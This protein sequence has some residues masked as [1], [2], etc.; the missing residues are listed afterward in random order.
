MSAKG[1]R[2]RTDVTT[3]IHLAWKRRLVP[4]AWLDFDHVGFASVVTFLVARSGAD[5]AVPTRRDAVRAELDA[6]RRPLDRELLVDA[7]WRASSESN[8][9]LLAV[10]DALAGESPAATGSGVEAS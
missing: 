9:A 3:L 10:I 2:I 4:L 7:V 6:V 1:T 5:W 8:P